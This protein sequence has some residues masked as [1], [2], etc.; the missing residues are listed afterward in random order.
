MRSHALPTVSAVAG[1]V[2]S[3]GVPVEGAT[4]NAFF[5][6]GS[7]YDLTDADGRFKFHDL[8]SG[9]LTLHATL[10]NREGIE[11]TNPERLSKSIKLNPGDSANVTIE[12]DR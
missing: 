11:N 7:D 8:P 6:V 12:F 5:G 1:V 2:M 9:S 3:H 4:V 10:P